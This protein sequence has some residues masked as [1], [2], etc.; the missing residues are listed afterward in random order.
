MTAKRLWI[1]LILLLVG[2]VIAIRLMT[3]AERLIGFADAQISNIS[4]FGFEASDAD[5]SI[6]SPLQLVYT[7]A[8]LV[9][10]TKPEQQFSLDSL[11]VWFDLMPSPSLARIAFASDKMSA[12]TVL[13]YLGAPFE[14]TSNLKVQG[15]FSFSGLA[16]G[17]LRMHGSQGV[18]DTREIER[19][20][21]GPVRWARD[22]GHFIDW[23]EMMAF[24][25]LHAEF[26]ASRGFDDTRFTLALENLKLTGSGTVDL[27]AQ[28]MEYDFELLLTSEGDQGDF[29]A[30]KLVADVPWPIRCRG[31]FDERLPCRLDFDALR[32]LALRLIAKDAEDAFSRTFGEVEH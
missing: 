22:S 24:E 25:I 27:L 9:H 16:K 5:W 18:L 29:R 10:S 11:R 32:A 14:L 1:P 7:D 20:N 17:T 30:G 23:P 8:H 26:D 12:R 3:Q 13:A 19:I 21:R 2:T 6:R 15:D 28:D 4:K 31:S